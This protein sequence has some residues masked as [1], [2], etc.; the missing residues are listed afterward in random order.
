MK[1]NDL[2]IIFIL[3]PAFIALNPA[4]GE[5]P[6]F[7]D[8]RIILERNIFDSERKSFREAP[9]AVT[10]LKEET[11][12]AIRLG[13][14]FAT[15]GE[16]SAYC[17]SSIPD[18]EGKWKKGDVIAGFTIKE[19]N[20]KAVR[21]ESEKNNIEWNI[22]ASLVKDRDEGWKASEQFIPVS[23]TKQDAEK[24]GADTDAGKSV[25]QKL[26]ERRRRQL[27]Q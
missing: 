23:G 19:I 13:G 15:D 14:V 25:L 9:P 16:Y 3:I 8:F 5:S 20:T 2:K 26:M 24:T 17:E 1:K 18:Y 27:S 7:S 22:G 4:F 11:L 10:E 21:L 12:T 6:E